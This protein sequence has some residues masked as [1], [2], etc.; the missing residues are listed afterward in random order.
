VDHVADLTPLI[1]AIERKRRSQ[2]DARRSRAY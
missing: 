2:E 1:T